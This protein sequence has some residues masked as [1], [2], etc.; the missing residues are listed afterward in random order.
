M[1]KTRTQAS[2]DEKVAEILDAAEARLREGGISALSIAAL[3]RKLGVAQ[4]AVYWYFPSR[5]HLLV[6]AME[7]MLADIIARKPKGDEA[8]EV[9]R[10]LWFTDQLQELSDLRGAMRE[11]ARGSEV[12]AEFVANLDESLSRM[13]TNVLS[14]RVAAEELP[15]AVAAFRATVDG[16]V[17]RGLPEDE[18]RRVLAYAL[19]RLID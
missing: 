14:D 16:A 1:P 17:A 13:L 3:A 9:E 18:R 8:D 19:E 7:R 11:R 12:V 4:N 5:D 2:R 10:V 15:L 6:A